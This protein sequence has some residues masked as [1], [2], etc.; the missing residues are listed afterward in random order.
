MGRFEEDGWLGEWYAMTRARSMVELREAMRPQAMLFGNV[1]GADTAGH[2]WYLYNGAVPRRDPRFNWQEPV[3][4]S[5]PATEWKGY[6]TIDDL[7]QLRDPKSGGMQNNNTTPFLLTDQGNPDPRFYPP[8]MVTEGDN[9]RG[10]RVRRLLAGHPKITWD[11]WVH[12][13]FDTRVQLADSLLPE[14]I[15]TA[16][17]AG[18]GSAERREALAVLERWNHQA[19]TASVAV[20]VLAKWSEQMD[21]VPEAQQDDPVVL[22]AALDSALASLKRDWGTWQVPW[23][24]VNRLQRYDDVDPEAGFRDANRSVAV[25]GVPGWLGAVFTMYTV[26]ADSQRSQYG[27][28]GGTYVSAVEL[29]PKVRAVAVHVFGT[30]DNPASPHYFD[31]APLFARGEMRPSWLALDEIKAHLERAYRPGEE[32]R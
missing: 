10:A 32:G 1:M 4:G 18:A 29:A 11:E 9:M 2:T 26:P 12:A 8:Y 20:T 30:S 15:A 22:A 14:M 24:K 6:H 31:Q 5:D 3:D 7:P 21:D 17:R 28:A 23:G 16:R 25:P 13:A 27:V 19:D